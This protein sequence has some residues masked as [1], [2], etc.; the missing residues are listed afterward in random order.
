MALADPEPQDTAEDKPKAKDLAKVHERALKRFDSVA[1]PQAEIRAHAL[2]CRR[3]ISI[4]GAMW[5]GPWGDQFENS[6]KVE[7][8][9]LSKGVEKIVGDYRANRIVPDFRPSGGNSDQDT[10]DTLDGLHRA[11]SYHF[12]AQQAR[13]NAFE[14][15]A[16]GGFGAYRL[17]NDYA[18]PAD[19][20]SDEQRVNPGLLIADADQ[21]VFFD[22]N[23]KLFDKSDAKWAFVLTAD[24]K[25][26]F[27]DEYP[28]CLSTWPET[29]LQVAYDWFAPDVVVKAEYYEVEERKQK[30]L[31]F[32]HLLT[33]AEERWW[34]DELDADEIKELKTR[35]YRMESKQRSRQRVRKYTL[36]G[37]E[38]LEDHGLIAGEFIP[39]VPCYG[40]RWFVDNQER[41][42]GHVSKLMDAQRIYNAKVSKLSETDSLAPREKPIFLAEQMPPNL[43]DLWSRQEQERH[44]YALV[45]PVIDSEGNYVAMGPIGK[46]E[47]P[48][49]QPVTA[50]LLQISAGDLQA[51]T[52][53][54]SDEV[55]AN[56]S[57]EAMD[58]A[59]T[60]ID[61][62]SG[63]YLDNMRQS[64]QREG[65][66]YLSMAKECYFEPGRKV[67]TMTEEGADGEAELHQNFTDATG[68]NRTRNDF[69]SGRYKVIADVTEAT[70]TRRDKTVKS[71]LH[72]AAVAAEVGDQELGQVAL[73][74]AVM[75]QDGE[76]VGS[77]QK[78][79]RKRLV[80]MGVEDPNDEEKAA[81]AEAQQEPDPNAQIAAAKT[82]DLGA[83]AQLKTAKAG[84]AQASTVL[85]IAQ[86]HAVGGPEAEPA[87]PDGLEAA[88]KVAQIDK[89]AAEAEH[90]RTTTEHLPEQLKIEAHNA[91]TNRMKAISDRVKR[92]IGGR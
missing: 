34:E 61:A 44:P 78:Y 9:K 54:G 26:A 2:L 89:T 76:G 84:E 57:A 12:K 25:E 51:E 29:R 86:A 23:S 92:F 39:I 8:D 46:I 37:A 53:D 80:G 49:L 7:I 4:P 42:R 75:N 47:P 1:T 36:S 81:M 24:S 13:D 22:G 40:K 79:A 18:D 38:V 45:N 62:K 77:V 68:V 85:K 55:K 33:Q 28:D 83:S 31:I 63:L 6:I 82:A 64:V 65:E 52:D 59:A 70:A 88:H 35:G 3:F 73:L 20:E 16:A 74:T 11:D 17:A 14:E 21:R 69:S 10:A 67:E 87:V 43:A 19:K 90:L 32:T 5:E 60:R 71:M 66:I 50:V 58:I 15:A 30:L 27:E 91:A 48:Q 72:T 56:T 41:F